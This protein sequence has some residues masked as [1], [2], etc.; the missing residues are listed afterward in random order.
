MHIIDVCAVI[1][2]K[3]MTKENVIIKIIILSGAY[4]R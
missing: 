3:D 2:I 1:L 4:D